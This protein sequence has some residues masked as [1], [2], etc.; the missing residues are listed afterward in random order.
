MNKK[1]V[2]LSGSFN[3]ITKA[4]RLILE[5]AVNKVNADLGLFV[6][7]SDAYLTKKII[8]KKKDKRPFILSEEIRKQMIDSLNEEFS[9]IKYGGIE[10]GRESPATLKT[11]KKL[12]KQYKRRKN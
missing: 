12:Q 3:P 9:F 1:L 10:L 7:V 6:I 5:N 2:V 4:H 11:L 8:L